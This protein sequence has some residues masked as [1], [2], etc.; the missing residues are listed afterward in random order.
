MIERLRDSSVFITGGTGPLGQSTAELLARDG[1]SVLIM[2][3]NEETVQ[4]V[5]HQVSVA[6]ERP[7]AVVPFVGDPLQTDD[8]RRGLRAAQELTGRLGA[9]VSTIGGVLGFKP[10]LT[11]DEKDLV[12]GLEYNVVSGFSVIR[13]ATPLLVEGGGGSIVCVTS[14][15]SNVPM[16]YLADYS[17]GKASLEALVKIAAKELAHLNVRVNAVRPG[18]IGDGSN[19]SVDDSRDL[20]KTIKEYHPLGRISSA[21]DVAGAIHYLLGAH[22]HSITG[23]SLGIDAGQEMVASPD[24]STLARTELGDR[25][26]DEAL[27]GRVATPA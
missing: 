15:A 25:T 2:G 9:A 5:A 17:I 1:A 19:T 4:Q 13:H 3:R 10:L 6:V 8:V 22:A 14:Y 24:F 21:Y 11:L 26:I 23:Q 20:Y 16:P 12:K 18:R 27:E 7:G